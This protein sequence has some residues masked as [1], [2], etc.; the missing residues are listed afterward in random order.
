MSYE[1]V[2]IGVSAGGLDAVCEIL[3]G[4]P[5]AF[6]FALIVVQHRSRDSYALCEVL[7]TCGGIPISEA[8]DKDPIEHGR[9]YLAPADYHLLVD[10]EHIALS[11]DAPEFYSRPSI[12]LAFESVAD[13]YRERAI[14][15]VLTGANRDGSR[16]LRK[17]VDRG[18]YALVQD[19]D[20]A[21]VAVMP[22]AAIHEVPDAEVLPLSRIAER[23]LSLVPLP[24]SEQ[25]ER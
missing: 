4:L 21:E 22:I 23:L 5:P 8:V 16:G 10:G 25:V 14:G 6:G 2:V 19:P 1:V 20:S 11:T 18:G 15:V 24:R 17:I 7:Q 9:V 3:R 12:D 13:A